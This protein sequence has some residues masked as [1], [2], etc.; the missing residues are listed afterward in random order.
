MKQSVRATNFSGSWYPDSGLDDV[1]EDLLGNVS[2]DDTVPAKIII[3]PHAG[4]SYSAQTAAYGFSKLNTDVETIFVLAPNH[5]ASLVTVSITPSDFVETP[6][7]NIPV[8]KD[9]RS[10]LLD[11]GLF[12]E[13]SPFQDTNEHSHELQFPFLKHLMNK[14]QTD[15]KILPMLVPSLQSGK[16]EDVANAL[17]PYFESNKF[18]F[19]ISS[20][21]CHYGKAFGYVLPASKT[22]D[23]PLHKAIEELDLRGAATIGSGYDAFYQYITETENTICGRNPILVMLKTIKISSKEGEWKVLNY[24]QS[25]PCRNNF[26]RSVSYCSMAFFEE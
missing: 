20:D 25:N 8:D 2:N 11:T 3:S 6:I 22:K 26:D 19:V 15:F 1:I 7:G 14:T 9:V 17:L 10:E 16:L 23:Q 24:S 13:L 4:Y 12:N 18:A 21:F 5:R